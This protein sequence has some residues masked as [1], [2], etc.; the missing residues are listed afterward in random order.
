MR[1]SAHDVALREYT[2]AP[3][4][5]IHVLTPL[6]SGTDVLDGIVRRQ[7][8]NTTIQGATEPPAG[9]PGSPRKA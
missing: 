3:P 6:E 8:E 2:I 9:G 7:E 4:S 5:G 1:F